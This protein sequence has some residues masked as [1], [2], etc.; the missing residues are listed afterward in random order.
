M[1]EFRH[2]FPE[3]VEGSELLRWFDTA[4]PGGSVSVYAAYPW[5]FLRQ[6]REH[7]VR[8]FQSWDG[9]NPAE[10]LD[11]LT[12]EK[13]STDWLIIRK[14]WMASLEVPA[15]RAS[16]AYEDQGFLVLRCSRQQ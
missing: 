16:V 7:L 3:Q 2:S 13:Q 15:D 11:R 4:A 9:S 1:E 5:Y 12:E 6:G 14:K 10:L 8:Y